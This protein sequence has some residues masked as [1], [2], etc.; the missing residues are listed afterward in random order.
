MTWIALLFLV[1]PMS[2]IVPASL[3]PH[4]Y[5]SLPD[6]EISFRHFVNMFT[7]KE[8]LSSI[9]DS[10]IVAFSATVV[11]VLL[12]TL[13][14]VG[15]W[16][17][18]SRRSEMVRMLMLTP[19][20]VP[21]IVHALGFYMVWVDLQLID[22]Y[23]G[24]ILAHVLIGMP[25]V[26]ITVSTSLVN[27]DVRQEQAAR[28]LGASMAQTVRKVIIPSIMPGIISGAIFAFVMSW[29]EIVVVLFITSRGVYTLPRKM[30]DGIQENYDPTIA[31]VATI[32]ILMTFVIL[33]ANLMFKVIQSRRAKVKS[34]EEG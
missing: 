33:F 4:R 26:V 21:P 6:D 14:A 32:L 3:T 31:A 8:W 5:L 27:F 9:G 11:A 34:V 29:D 2:V 18:A 10:L 23:V 24:V 12:G 20:I 30:W 13:C 7:N 28:N 1:M 22:T 15:C 17:I 19:I 25:F 16:R